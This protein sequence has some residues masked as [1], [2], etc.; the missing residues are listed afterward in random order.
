MN[1]RNL[2]K[3]IGTG[4]F[5]IVNGECDYGISFKVENN[6]ICMYGKK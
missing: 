4:G 3:T 2:L 5:I 6:S 1:R